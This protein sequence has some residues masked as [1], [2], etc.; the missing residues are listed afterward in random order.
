M[1][2]DRFRWEYRFLSNFYPESF[3]FKGSTYMTAEHAYQT[4]K[5]V[6]P[7][8]AQW[9]KAARTPGKA[10]RRG[11][12]V[13]IWYDWDKRKQGV[14]LEIVRA[15]FKNEELS[16]LLLATGNEGLMEGNDWSDVFWGV[17]GGKGENHLGKILMQVR[18]ELRDG[19]RN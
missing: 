15:K 19:T 14:M 7:L 16:R 10:K 2:I 8:D 4:A 17:C 6:D 12:K 3:I 1:T 13:K 9:V 5:A 18:K 11:R